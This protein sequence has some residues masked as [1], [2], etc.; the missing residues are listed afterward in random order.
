MIYL[1]HD[2]LGNIINYQPFQQKYRPHEKIQT[3][4]LQYLNDNIVCR[5]TYVH[6]IYVSLIYKYGC[7]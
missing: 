2:R 5:K 7:S 6:F 1:Q 4:F 3:Q